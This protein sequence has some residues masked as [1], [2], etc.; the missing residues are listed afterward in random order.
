MILQIE[1]VQKAF[2]KKTALEDV[3]LTIKPG[4]F[5]LLGPNGAGKTTLMRIL[6][7]ILR[8][9]R[10]SITAD[11]IDWTRDAHRVRAML[12]YLP[13]DFGIFRNVTAREVLAYI[14]TLKGVEKGQLKRQIDAVLEEVN[15]TAHADKKVGTFSGGMRRRLGIA[16]ALLGDPKLIVIDEPTAG[17]DPEERVRFRLLLRRLVREERVV[18]LSTHIVGDVEAVCD[19]LAVIKKGKAHLFAS[20]EELA[21]VADGRVWRWV[22]DAREYALLEEKYRIVS[23]V[24]RGSTMEARILSDTRPSEAAEP[25]TPS[26]EEGYLVWVGE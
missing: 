2:R 25:A 11:G 24:S 8:P 9:D 15:L 10:G 1:Q 23:S 20:P 12:G 5:G 4:I 14:G 7:T 6:A 13:Q 22:G 3:T 21:Q 19:Q 17:L 18:V 16:Q 26:L